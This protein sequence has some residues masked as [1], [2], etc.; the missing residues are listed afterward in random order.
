MVVIGGEA[1]FGALYKIDLSALDPPSETRIQPLLHQK[2][3]AC[4]SAH[5]LLSESSVASVFT[6]LKFGV[7]V[8]RPG[9]SCEGFRAAQH[10][11]WPRQWAG[12]LSP[13]LQPHDLR[14]EGRPEVQDAAAGARGGRRSAQIQGL[15]RLED[16][17]GRLRAPLRAPNARVR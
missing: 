14:L 10:H 12:H 5:E 13:A 1:G 2:K 7:G 15:R 8:R 16:S 6:V 4:G 9:S 3:S 11:V 17:I